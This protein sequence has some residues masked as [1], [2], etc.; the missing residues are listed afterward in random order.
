MWDNINKGIRK[1]EVYNMMGK[2]KRII[3]IFLSLVLVLGIVP[4]IGFTSKAVDYAIRIGD[5]GG[6]INRNSGASGAGWRY[7]P[8][9]G[10]KIW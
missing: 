3:G 5:S 8:P 10:S 1:G 9:T 7:T 4:M 2:T 6:V